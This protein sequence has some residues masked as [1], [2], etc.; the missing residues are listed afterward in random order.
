MA[1]EQARGEAV[2]H[3]CDLFS[4]GCVLYRMCTGATPFKGTDVMSA[5]LSLAMDHPPAPRQRNPE[6]PPALDKLILRLLAKSVP[7]RPSSAQAVVEAIQRIEKAPATG[8]ETVTTSAP[9]IAQPVGE[10]IPPQAV[11]VARPVSK[12]PRRRTLAVAVA[13]GMLLVAGVVLAGQIILKITRPGGKTTEQSNEGNKEPPAKAGDADRRAA[14]WV[15][16]I[17]GTIKIRQDGQERFISA[18]KDLP[19]APFEVVFVSLGNNQKADDAG[20]EHLQGLG[21]LTG[22]ALNNAWVSDSGLVHLKRL[23]NLQEIRLEHTRVSDAGMA[24]LKSLTKLTGLY[25]GGTQVSGSGL[26]H[27]EGLTN[28]T[29]LSLH[30]T[31]VSDAGLEHLRALTNLAHLYLDGT[32]VTDAGLEHLKGLTN[33]TEL[34]LLYTRVTD[35]GLGHLKALTKLTSLHLSTQVS[36]AGLGHLKALTKLTGLYLGGTQVTDAGLEHLKGLTS[37]TWLY[38]PRTR[39]SDAGL[40][41]LKGLNKLTF[42]DLDDTRV[43]D[44]GLRDLVNLPLHDIKLDHSR[45]SARGFANLRSAFPGARVMGEPRPSVAE[46]MLAE[47]ATLVIL[48]GQGKEDRLVKKIVDLPHERFLVRRADCTRVKKPLAELL[49]HLSWPREYEFE[50]LEALDLSGCAIDNLGF[51]PPLESLQ[52][53]NV[54]GTRVADLQPVSGLKRLRKLSLERTPVSGLGPVAGLIKLEELS[55]A[56][57]PMADNALQALENLPNL[58]KLNLNQTGVIGRGLGYLVKLPKLA[59]LSLAGSKVSDLLAAEVGALTMLERLSL[60]GCTFSD[61]GLKHLAGMSNLTQLDLTGTQATADGVA[62][63]QKALPKCKI[64][65]GAAPQ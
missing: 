43:S 18:A 59:E 31:R 49:A 60:A 28:L 64:I 26:V 33:L 51:A 36:D 3:R 19:A 16:S 25:L 15:L 23:T 56:G 12:A 13:A 8:L 42:L 10:P 55:L 40:V 5:L 54:S 7:D 4:L 45:V 35:A 27:L 37:L 52:E 34:S 30:S 47:G 61:A 62:A 39:V 2:D 17:G 29:E 11:P 46:D 53:L 14:E 63:L 6:V 20:L 21:N 9:P 50:R 58:R 32:Q 57:T 44:A 1:P 65:S 22:L 41:H 24:H 38:L 48:A